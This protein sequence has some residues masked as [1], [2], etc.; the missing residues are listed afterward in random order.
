MKLKANATEY[1]KKKRKKN[2]MKD[3]TSKNSS[4]QEIK[5]KDL[6]FEVMKRYKYLGIAINDNNNNETAQS[7]LIEK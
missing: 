5:I 1:R 7:R 6:G 2:M 3:K 4:M